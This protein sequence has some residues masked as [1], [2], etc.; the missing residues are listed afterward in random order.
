MINTSWCIFGEFA[1]L[2]A[3][4]WDRNCACK[5]TRYLTHSPRPSRP[6]RLQTL[7][8]FCP[9]MLCFLCLSYGTSLRRCFLW[10]CSRRSAQSRRTPLPFMDKRASLPWPARTAPKIA[11][12]LRAWFPFWPRWAARCPSALLWVP[13]S[14]CVPFA[15][16]T[17]ASFCTTHLFAFGFC[18]ARLD[19]SS[20]P[21]RRVAWLPKSICQIEPYSFLS[22]ALP[23]PLSFFASIALSLSIL[24]ASSLPTQESRLKCWMPALQSE[25]PLQSQDRTCDPKSI[26]MRFRD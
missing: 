3:V 10:C 13:V 6:T 14:R 17:R 16:A 12:A 4:L 21:P 7:P 11:I 23:P 22:L 20:L 26:F 25:L 5:G 1:L 15:F 9:G 2:P 18:L 24:R 19:V 8:R